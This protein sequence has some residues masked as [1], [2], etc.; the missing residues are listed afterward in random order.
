MN[1]SLK[2]PNI[3]LINCDDLGYGDLGCY[4]SKINKTCRILCS[5]DRSLR[6]RIETFLYKIILICSGV[7]DINNLLAKIVLES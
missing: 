4:G 3:L 2:K 6:Y 7:E 5:E 1:S